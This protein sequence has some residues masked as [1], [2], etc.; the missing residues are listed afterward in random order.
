M[1][2]SKANPEYFNGVLKAFR[3]NLRRA[4]RYAGEDEVG[5][6][7]RITLDELASNTG[8]ARSTVAKYLGGTAKTVDPNPDLQ[9]I[10]ALAQTLSV[11]PAFLLMRPQ[12]WLDLVAA[13]KQVAIA[14]GD[15][16]I[17]D[18]AATLRS[19]WEKNGWESS[20]NETQKTVGSIA[21]RACQPLHPN[22]RLA[23]RS[24]LA[25]DSIFGMMDQTDSDRKLERHHQN[26]RRAVRCISALPD[27]AGMK[28]L[29]YTEPT[30]TKK[31]G[32]SEKDEGFDSILAAVFAFCL[33]M[34][35]KQHKFDIN[36]E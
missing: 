27:V 33:Q 35:Q 6:A 19:T 5:D 21:Y 26:V 16:V 14:L 20:E 13:S 28:N 22:R 34:G 36:H 1:R 29:Y 7:K 24:E 12:D 4:V 15:E 2:K 30:G 18:L 3:A 17:I 9:S 11:P 25:T 23:K 31:G 32:E 8:I 10:C